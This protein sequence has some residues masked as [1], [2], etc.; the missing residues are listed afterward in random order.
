MSC[1]LNIE[2][3][4]DVCS[5]AVSQDG[6]CIFNKEDNDGPNH[7]VSLGI[8]VDEALTYIDNRDIRLDR[9]HGRMPKKSRPAE[10]GGKDDGQ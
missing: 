8:F 3:S 4:T 9:K 6:V 5:V 2:T 1:I 10:D 7:A